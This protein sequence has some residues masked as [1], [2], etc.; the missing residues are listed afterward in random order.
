M[1][2]TIMILFTL[3]AVLSILILGC[4]APEP[5]VSTAPSGDVAG[6]VT[7]DA[8]VAGELDELDEL[9]QLGSELDDLEWEEAEEAVKG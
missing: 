9:D 7:E 3:L 2:T 4:T 8:E 6:E 1:K 5:A